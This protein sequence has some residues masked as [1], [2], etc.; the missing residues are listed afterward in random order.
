MSLA[1]YRVTDAFPQGEAL[2]EQLRR[3]A[4]EIVGDLTG[5]DFG[6]A[7]K[8]IAII[9]NYF[10]IARPQNW[11]KEINW[12]I[13]KNEYQFLSQSLVLEEKI[14]EAGILDRKSQE[15]A[16]KPSIM[17]HNIRKTEKRV[18]EPIL[19]DFDISSRQEKILAEI[20]KRNKAK[21]SEL[22]PLFKTVSART[23]RNDI[24]FLL[25]KKL[26]V[27]EGFNKSATYRSV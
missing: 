27:K 7:Q 19:K 18:Q 23:L 21:I 1:I 12:L 2:S 3:L 16:K 5:G 6:C 17:S 9:L 8:K 22:V 20:N 24:S 25:E 13:L 10:K 14:Q 15:E 26:I 4:N 11:V